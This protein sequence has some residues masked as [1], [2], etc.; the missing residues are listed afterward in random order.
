MILTVVRSTKPRTLGNNR[1][2]VRCE[3]GH[4]FTARITHMK[5][6]KAKCKRCESAASRQIGA[7]DIR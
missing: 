5:Q 2:W 6:G 7:K 1:L 4:R 3:R